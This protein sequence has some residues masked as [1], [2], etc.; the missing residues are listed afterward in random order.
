[1]KFQSI[2]EQDIP[3]VKDD[4]SYEVLNVKMSGYDCNS[5]E[6]FTQYVHNLARRLELDVIEWYVNLVNK[7]LLLHNINVKK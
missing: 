6:H 5:V 3:E 7:F 2:P 4:H 1:M